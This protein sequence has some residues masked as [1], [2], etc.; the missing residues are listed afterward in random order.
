MGFCLQSKRISHSGTAPRQIADEKR[1]WSVDH[2]T[3]SGKPD[4]LKA[5]RRSRPWEATENPVEGILKQV[6]TAVLSCH[7][8]PLCGRRLGWA[9]IGGTRGEGRGRSRCALIAYRITE[10]SRAL[11]QGRG[12]L[13]R[14]DCWWSIDAIDVSAN[15][16]QGG[17]R[18][19]VGVSGRITS[20]R[21]ACLVGAAVRYDLHA[22]L[23]YTLSGTGAA[24]TMRTSSR[25]K[26][27]TRS[28]MVVLAWKRNSLT[29]AVSQH[30][31]SPVTPCHICSARR[32][33]RH[34][35]TK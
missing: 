3:R 16:D 13:Y 20:T 26:I 17:R 33:K 14:F 31:C 21:A 4:K 32:P 35:K 22:I 2:I 5:R 30:P 18:R 29:S 1:K 6:H 25:S 24:V 19:C 23:K 10:S 9:E 12:D 27:C 15:D 11:L 8:L 34:K 7:A 28:G